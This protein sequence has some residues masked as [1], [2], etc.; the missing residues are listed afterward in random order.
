M[1]NAEF[2]RE[3]SL[4]HFSAKPV[5]VGV[6]VVTGA[7]IV[8]STLLGNSDAQIAKAEPKSAAAVSLMDA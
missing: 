3:H 1:T 8:I 7:A 2:S 4:V 6:A 5:K